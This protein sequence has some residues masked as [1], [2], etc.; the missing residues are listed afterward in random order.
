MFDLFREIYQTL[1][2]NKLR[3]FLTGVSVAWGIFMLIILLGMAR[4]VVND[5]ES[6]RGSAGMNTISVYGGRTSKAHAGYKEG[7]T[8]QLKNKDT[9]NVISEGEGHV[10]EATTYINGKASV[11][12]TP[13][14]YI[15]VRYRGVYPS[16]FRLNGDE[17]QEGRF[18]N[19]ADMEYRRKV[20]VLTRK[21]A[22]IL[23]EDST[24]IIGGKVKLGGLAFTVIGVYDPEWGEDT[25]VPYTT[26]KMINGD[27]DDVDNLTVTIQNVSTEEDGE[28]VEDN[29]R[30]TL[31]NTHNFDAE[32][33]SAVWVWNDFTQYFK[34]QSGFN[35]M[36]IVIWLIGIFTMLSGIVGV[37][38]I[39]FVSVKERT[40]E[41]GIR[42]AI[43]AKPRNILTQILT[44]S[45]AITALFGYI[46]I[47]FGIIATEGISMIPMTGIKNPTVDITI[48]IEV[49]IV[50]IISGC[51]AGLFPALKALKVK[52]VEALRDE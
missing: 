36:N 45:V 35:I 20:I 12:S 47:F 50:L 8:I 10:K 19:D 41:I 32:D 6:H 21:N 43:G 16:F 48:A 25:F 37:S 17:I 2:N 3:T 1:R 46:G 40:H 4:G 15:S 27:S 29:I 5:F 26:A 28:K 7:R 49:T 34:V 14:D 38:N 9:E 13:H 31:A 52:P 42:R 11:I 51:L 23:F 24:K 22:N 33:K 44:E 30:R 18:I 39:M